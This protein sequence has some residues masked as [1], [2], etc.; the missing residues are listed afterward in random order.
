MERVV[1]N[2]RKKSY[3]ILGMSLLG[4]ALFIQGCGDDDPTNVG[5]VVEEIISCSAENE[6]TINGAFETG[7]ETGWLFFDAST[8]NGGTVELI[9]TDSSCGTHSASV[10]SGPT[11]NPGIKQERFAVGV[12][13]ANQKVNV[14]F[15]YKAIQ[16]DG[17]AI[18]NVLAFTEGAADV[19]THPLA[20]AYVPPVGDWSTATYSFTTGPDATGGISL[21]LEVVCGGDG[22]CAGQVLFDKVSVTVE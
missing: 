5:D 6:L 17:G 4:C 3:F 7:D 13:T 15:D 19:A 8:T 11:N 12:V 22:G 2:G 16:L 20:L 1:K 10:T 9:D 14:S 21:L 18:I